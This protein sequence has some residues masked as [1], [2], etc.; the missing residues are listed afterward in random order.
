M[1]RSGGILGELKTWGFLMLWE[2]TFG[3]MINVSHS[4]PCPQCLVLAAEAWG[5]GSGCLRESS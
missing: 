1:G 4:C 3:K 5:W 2:M